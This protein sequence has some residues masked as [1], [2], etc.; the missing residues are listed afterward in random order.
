[1]R[2]ADV[3]PVCFSGGAGISSGR[4]EGRLPTMVGNQDVTEFTRV[5]ESRDNPFTV[6]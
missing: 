3:S 5:G 1:L 6:A 4:D 2:R